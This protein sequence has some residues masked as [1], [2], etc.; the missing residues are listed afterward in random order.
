MVRIKIDF[1]PK[2]DPMK[3]I[4]YWTVI[5]ETAYYHFNIR[6]LWKHRPSLVLARNK[7]K[8]TKMLRFHWDL[9]DLLT[10]QRFGYSVMT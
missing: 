7:L 3:Q 8:L 2:V 6:C 1:F 10:T 4:K 9:S 5:K